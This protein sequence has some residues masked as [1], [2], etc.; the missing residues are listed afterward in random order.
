[1]LAIRA[2]DLSK[3]YGA[4]AAPVY[5][6]RGVSLQVERGERVALPCHCVKQIMVSR[7]GSFFLFFCRVISPFVEFFHRG[8]PKPYV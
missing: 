7:R 6:L 4:S 3:S 8:R 2:L 5:A 1:M